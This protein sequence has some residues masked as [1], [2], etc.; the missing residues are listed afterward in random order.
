[1]QGQIVAV[2]ISKVYA[3]RLKDLGI[4]KL[5]FVDSAQCTS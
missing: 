3:I 1:M 2:K 4:R 5:D